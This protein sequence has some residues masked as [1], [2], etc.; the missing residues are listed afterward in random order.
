MLTS[1]DLDSDQD[2]NEIMEDTKDE[3][4]Q[5]GDLKNIIIPRSGLG[6]TKI[7][8]EYNTSEDA[9]K[10]IKALAGR[11]FDGRTIDASF[12]DKEKYWR[13]DYSD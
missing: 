8:L 7:F 11:T 10:A 2:Y 12:M 9:A 4:S 1:D 3:C 6:A 5:F 13:E